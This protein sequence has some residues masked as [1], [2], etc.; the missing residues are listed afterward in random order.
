MS[1]EDQVK[2]KGPP[3]FT[4]STEMGS[5]HAVTAGSQH[6]HRKLR[7]KE[8]QLFAIGGAIGTCKFNCLSLTFAVIGNS[9]N[10]WKNRRMGFKD[11]W[12][13]NCNSTFCT[14]GERSS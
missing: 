3:K 7:S 11:E 4:E 9:V 12:L 8:V 14:N 2:E 6:L 13:I 10:D 5:M 1:T